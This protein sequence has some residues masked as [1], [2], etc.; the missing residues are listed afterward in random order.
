VGNKCV[1]GND[2]AVWLSREIGTESI[3]LRGEID[4]ANA[5]PISVTVH[6]P[7]ALVATVLHDAL[8]RAGVGVPPN[9]AAATSRID[10]SDGWEVLAVHQTRLRDVLWRANKDSM[11]LYAEAMCKR[12]GAH[13]TKQPGSWANGTAAVAAYLQSIGVPPEQF[14]IVD[15]CGLARGNRLSPAALIR[16]LEH[17]ALGKNAD[18]YL[19]SLAVAGV[20]GTL[21][22]RFTRGGEGQVIGKSGFIDGVSS[23]TGFAADAQGRRVAFSILFNGIDK[24]T[25]SK[26]KAIQEQIVRAIR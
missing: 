5:E 15:G 18:V 3:V 16:V 4:R 9:P 14:K 1:S 23:L 2:N 24:G 11:N 10:L 25:N 19:A 6:E 22:S 7:P 17:E 8:K 12:L 21:K 13:A 20:D 26:A